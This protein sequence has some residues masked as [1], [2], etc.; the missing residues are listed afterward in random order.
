[1][2]VLQNY[3]FKKA[4]VREGKYKWPELLDGQTRQLDRGKDY[5]CK[6][7]NF[8]MMARKAAKKLGLSVRVDKIQS[9]LVIQAV[10]AISKEEKDQRQAAVQ[11]KSKK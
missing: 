8:A 10:K 6:D 7:A 2:K 5:S 11:K 3:E 9:G 1:M 4:Q